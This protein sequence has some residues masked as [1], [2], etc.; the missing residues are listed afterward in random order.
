MRPGDEVVVRDPRQRKAGGRTPYKQP[1]TDPALVLEIHGN[2]ATLKA[3]DGRIL[4]DIHLEDVML[5]PENARS[6]EK[7]PLQ[8]EEEEGTFLD[9]MIQCPT[10]TRS[11][12]RR[13]RKKCGSAS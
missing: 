11:N 9:D 1:Y 13:S 12:V 8:I 4:K 7:E 10:V 2:K 6:L 3:K 5:V